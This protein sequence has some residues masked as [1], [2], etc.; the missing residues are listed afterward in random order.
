MVLLMT[1]VHCRQRMTKGLGTVSWSSSGTFCDKEVVERGQGLVGGS[2]APS[3]QRGAITPGLYG[4]TAL[5]E[6]TFF[7]DRHLVHGGSGTC[8]HLAWG[9]SGPPDL[10][11]AWWRE[12]S[13]SPEAAQNTRLGSTPAGTATATLRSLQL[14]VFADALPP[15]VQ[16]PGSST[17]FTP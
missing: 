9:S 4:F 8:C 15:P 5:V 16:A 12:H 3:I 2:G 11:K 10:Q 14:F 17:F 1:V 7:H 13:L 6:T